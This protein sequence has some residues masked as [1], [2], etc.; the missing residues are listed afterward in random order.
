M[1]GFIHGDANHFYVHINNL[2]KYMHTSYI[3]FLSE[4]IKLILLFYYKHA[5]QNIVYILLVPAI[6]KYFKSQ[7]LKWLWVNI[8]DKTTN[9][10][11]VR[12]FNRIVWWFDLLVFYMQHFKIL[13]KDLKTQNVLSCLMH[14]WFNSCT[15]LSEMQCNFEVDCAI[16]F[17][18]E[19]KFVQLVL[20]NYWL[21]L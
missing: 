6:E 21:Y 2:H 16:S 15:Y 8:R 5:P 13:T 14:R 18:Y 3:I 10:W 12:S 7:K 19:L 11:V 1:E 17:Y 20:I 9:M 4:I